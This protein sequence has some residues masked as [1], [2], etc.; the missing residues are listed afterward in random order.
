M[1]CRVIN[2]LFVRRFVTFNVY[3]IPCIERNALG[4]VKAVTAAQLALSGDGI[5][6]VSLDEAIAAMRQTAKDMSSKYVGNALRAPFTSA[7]HSFCLGDLRLRLFSHCTN[8]DCRYK[9]TSR[10]GLAVC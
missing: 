10:A 2:Q 1:T 4:A 7:F 5:H 9:E 6:S 3:Q 8:D